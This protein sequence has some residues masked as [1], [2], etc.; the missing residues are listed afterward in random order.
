MRYSHLSVLIL[1]FSTLA[2]AIPARPR[3]GG[4][5]G[6]LGGGFHPNRPPRPPATPSPRPGL[7]A[8]PGTLPAKPGVGG[9][10]KPGGHFGGGPGPIKPPVNKPVHPPGG[11]PGGHPGAGDLG[12]F[13]GTP[14][15][16]HFPGSP[17][18]RPGYAGYHKNE[19]TQNIYRHF[20]YHPNYGYPFGKDWCNHF[21]W[22]Y[23]RWPY[24]TAAASGVAI[25]GWVGAS[26]YSGYGS[27]QQVVYYPVEPAP[28]AVYQQ[29]VT[30]PAAA[31]SQGQMAKVDDDAEWM[32][33]GAY[34]II[35]YQQKDFAYAVQLATTKDGVVRGIQWDMKANTSSEVSGSIDKKTTK[36]AWAASAPGS[37]MF[38]TNVDEL[39]QQESMV[40][41]YDPTT[42]GLVSWQL[43]QISEKDLPK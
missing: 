40:N 3:P 16:G 13:L 26:S 23:T 27:S 8:K 32:N 10:G 33:V 12:K 1:F 9:P 43:I 41:V 6:G 7:G 37:L 19:F 29:S 34:G 2:S 22:H 24:W 25:A 39:T 14:Q 31:V 42:K 20:P 15:P 18:Y 35:P 11:Y 38:E 4:G 30:E 36:V 28:P 21:H 17:G 5:G